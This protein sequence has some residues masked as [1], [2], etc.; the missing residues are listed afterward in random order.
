MN[1]ISLLINNVILIG[2]HIDTPDGIIV[3][4]PYSIQNNGQE[5]IL[6][7]FLENLIGQNVESIPLRQEHILASFDAE[8]NELLQGYLQKIS[9]I[10]LTQQ[11]IIT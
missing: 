2:F 10:S 8:N 5:Y 6:T 1:K 3:K 11:E 7:P 4:K 9:G